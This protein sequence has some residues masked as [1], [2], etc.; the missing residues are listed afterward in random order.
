M[1][2]ESE[3]AVIL[4]SADGRAV[5]EALLQTTPSIA[6]IVDGKGWILR[7]SRHACELSGL[8]AEEME[9]LSLDEFIA[10]V[11]PRAPDGRLLKPDQQPLVRA[12][13]GFTQIGRQGFF[14]DAGGQRVPVVSNVAP[15]RNSAGDVIGAISAVTDLRPFRALE[16]KLR[17]AIDEKEVLYQELAHRVKNHLQVVS[18]L[19]ALEGR[20]G[21][22]EAQALADRLIGRLDM[23]TAMYESR[24][25]AKTGGR[26]QGRPFIEQVARPYRSDR[27]EVVVSVPAGATLAPDHAGPVG[28]LVN[29]AVCN[30]YKHAF[31]ER[32][33]RITVALRQPS[34]DC[35]DLEITDDGVGFPPKTAGPDCQGVR[36]MRLLARQLGGE[37]TISARVG[38]GASI[39]A[40]LPISVGVEPA[41]EARAWP[42]RR[43]PS[44]RHM[45][46]R[47][48]H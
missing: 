46:S 44:P 41:V 34:P 15:F 1:E 26:I 10:L 5:V 38:G 48:S 39:L 31:P 21:T 23:L 20:Q 12:L 16:A 36:L 25:M 4:H 19:V 13:K 18:G 7:V 8:S 3:L 42:A 2:Q 24:N 14:R 9:G 27:V 17:A 30:S 43:R 29:E 32:R 11:Q 33:G 6:V 47:P 28:M 37:L 40:R 22:P 45:E 35:V